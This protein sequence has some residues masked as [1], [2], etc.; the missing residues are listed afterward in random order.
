MNASVRMSGLLLA[1]ALLA[2]IAGVQAQYELVYEYQG[3]AYAT[4]GV[5]SDEREALQQLAGDYNLHLM[6]AATSGN[7]VA[8][9]GVRIVDSQGRSLLE[10]ES[11]G[12]LL[13]ARL[14][15][16]SYTVEVSGFGRTQRRQV[17]VDGGRPV[18]V[19]FF[20]RA[21]PMGRSE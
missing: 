6:F 1:A 7:F 13:Y 11:D 15:R 3:I 9:I 2:P 4:G 14:P 5:G 17:S 16:G 10:A 8:D 19:N 20:W 12:P 21:P 18:R